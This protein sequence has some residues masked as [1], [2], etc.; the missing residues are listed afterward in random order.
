V[1]LLFSVLVFSIARRRLDT[2]V[3]KEEDR[4]SAE[5]WKRYEELGL[6][7]EISPTATQTRASAIWPDKNCEKIEKHT[8]KHKQ[9]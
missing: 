5:V 1:P 9:I 6:K 4:L 7:F 2:F 3:E 8:T